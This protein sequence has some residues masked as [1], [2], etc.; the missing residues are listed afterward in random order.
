[1]A[2]GPQSFPVIP[3]PSDLLKLV[4]FTSEFS[5]GV[6]GEI[7]FASFPQ[8]RGHVNAHTYTITA[9]P[10]LIVHKVV[11]RKFPT[12]QLKCTCELCNIVCFIHKILSLN[13]NNRVAK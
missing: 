13:Q 9:V 10:S 2:P 3:K 8:G 7:L 6:H 5:E 1:M 11:L 4:L 12:F